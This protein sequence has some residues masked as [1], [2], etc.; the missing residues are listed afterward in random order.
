MNAKTK[1]NLYYNEYYDL[2]FK[3]ILK[4]IGRQD[5]SS[6]IIQEVFIAFYNSIEKIDNPKAW[7]FKV[8]KYQ[9]IKY[10][11]EKKDNTVSIDEEAFNEL[12]DERVLN[13]QLEHYEKL[14]IIVDKY[15]KKSRDKEIFL[16]F[17]GKNYK[18]EGIADLMSL[19]AKQV[20]YSIDKVK[21]IIYS[22]FVGKE[23]NNIEDL[24]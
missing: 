8:A 1:F 14:K 19:S 13:S 10:F 2:I 6:D 17:F 16:L 5:I 24:F 22:H 9:M 3:Y 15:C 11:K 18:I 20:R 4:N 21:K 23:V 12:H 7:L